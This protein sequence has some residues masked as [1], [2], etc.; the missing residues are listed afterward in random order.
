MDHAFAHPLVYIQTVYDVVGASLALEAASR[1]N[2]QEFCHDFE[3]FMAPPTRVLARDDA[4]LKNA[5]VL[6]PAC[7]L[8]LRWT[9]EEADVESWAKRLEESMKIVTASPVH[10]SLPFSS[11]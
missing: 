3:L 2:G 4:S 5:K 1:D 11:R 8:H 6:A 10:P 9:S 7:V